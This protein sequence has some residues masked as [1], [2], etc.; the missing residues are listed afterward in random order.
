MPLDLADY[1]KRAHNH[2]WDGTT[3]R[4]SCEDDM[5]A[6]LDEL[7]GEYWRGMNDA[8]QLIRAQRGPYAY[9]HALIA[10]KQALPERKG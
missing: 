8:L 4:W 6:L 2:K 10:V 3:G 5:N 1:H 7:E 9:D